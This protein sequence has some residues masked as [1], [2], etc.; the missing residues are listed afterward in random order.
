M[1]QSTKNG[2]KPT[3][4]LYRP[5]QRQQ[6]RLQRIARRRRRRT[7][8]VSTLVAVVLI[9]LGSIGFWQFQVYTDHQHVLAAS[10]TA[11]ATTKAHVQA[12]AKAN[13]SV[14]AAVQA[15]ATSVAQAVSTAYAGS[16]TP[17]A[18][19]ASP[20]VVTLP[21]TKTKDGLQY[22]DIKVGTGAE[23]KTGSTVLAEYSGWI[24]STGKKF[25]SSFDHAGQPIE[26]TP[27]GTAQII[28][29]WNEG[30]IGMKVGGTRRLIIPPSLAYGSQ[31][32]GPI[33]ANATL[34]FDVTVVSVK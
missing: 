17:S 5:G 33:P 10:A 32:Q 23:A 30:L 26:V 25:D 27:L 9:I 2:T 29:G 15:S 24:Q 21:A 16:P 12:T 3:Q 7:I 28:P 22:I 6:E 14:T 13:A 11:T 18:G 31:A 34:I 19:P 8:I 1:T 20:P 4:K